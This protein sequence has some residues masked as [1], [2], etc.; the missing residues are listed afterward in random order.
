[1]A[2]GIIGS[3]DRIR[4]AVIVGRYPVHLFFGYIGDDVERI[5]NSVYQD[6]P[7]H[8]GL[9]NRRKKDLIFTTF[10]Q[11]HPS[12]RNVHGE[13]I[14]RRLMYVDAGQYAA[15]ACLLASYQHRRPAG[16]P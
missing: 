2:F 6:Y 10:R 4:A 1:M 11:S 3:D 16:S 13:R 9:F 12:G 7:L 5:I 8:P 14:T 15:A